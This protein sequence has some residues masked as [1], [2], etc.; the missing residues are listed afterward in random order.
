MMKQTD[1]LQSRLAKLESWQQ[2]AFAAAMVQ[3]MAANYL[4]FAELLAE[5][6]A[7]QSDPDGQPVDEWPKVFRNVLG[8]V[9]EYC[10]GINSQVDFHKQLTKVEAITPDPE[11]YDFYGV[12]PALDA[13]AALSALVSCAEKLDS[14]ELLQIAELSSSTIY[15][16]LEAMEQ[17]EEQA[18]DDEHPLVL[19][20]S[21]FLEQ[22]L[23]RAAPA[24]VSLNR[25]EQVAEL[26]RWVQG[27]GVSNIGV[28]M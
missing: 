8:L 28:E 13:A 21:A 16:Y 11:A 17:I 4:L 25:R 18:G 22:A 9:W 23:E 12:W 2:L 5:Q 6:G 26:R 15:G 3:R 19:A 1:F 7:S 20:E 14:D 27:Q 10:G 24:S